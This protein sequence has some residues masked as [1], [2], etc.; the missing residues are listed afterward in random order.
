MSISC[1]QLLCTWFHV[2]AHVR[3]R[4]A[5]ASSRDTF[6]SDTFKTHFKLDTHAYNVKV[7]LIIPLAF[8]HL[9]IY[10]SICLQ[11]SL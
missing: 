9:F 5:N 11:K 1:K 6:M 3:E 8:L 10:F 4:G 7:I 2:L